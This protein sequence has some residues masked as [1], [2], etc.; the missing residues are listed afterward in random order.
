MKSSWQQ[1]MNRLFLL[2]PLAFEEQVTQGHRFGKCGTQG[3]LQADTFLGRPHCCAQT[4]QRPMRRIADNNAAGPCICAEASRADVDLHPFVMIDDRVFPLMRDHPEG[5]AHRLP[6]FLDRVA[7][8]VQ[9]AV[10][11]ALPIRDRS[12]QAATGALPPSACSVAAIFDSMS[13]PWHLLLKLSAQ[14]SRIF[15]GQE[16]DNRFSVRRTSCC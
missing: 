8:R 12:G 2:R 16:S 7:D 9:G 11:A 6:C 10:H 1:G 15:T 14:R 4:L 13:T 5:L 3:R